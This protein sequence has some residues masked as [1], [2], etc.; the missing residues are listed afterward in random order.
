MAV[1]RTGA[2]FQQA[3]AACLAAGMLDLTVSEPAKA[4]GTYIACFLVR[5]IR[6]YFRIGDRY[7]QAEPNS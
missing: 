2:L 1:M 3:E 5:R 6:F 7:G 4:A